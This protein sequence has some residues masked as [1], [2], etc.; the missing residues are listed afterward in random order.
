MRVS[1]NLTSGVPYRREIGS[2]RHRARGRLLC[3][4]RGREGRDARVSQGLPATRCRE[5][6]REDTSLELSEGAWLC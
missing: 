3:E 1:P 4:D 6:V 5:E 2:E